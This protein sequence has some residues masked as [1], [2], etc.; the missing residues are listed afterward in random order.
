MDHRDTIIER[1]YNATVTL[2]VANRISRGIRL[3]GDSKI[4]DR[5]AILRGRLTGALKI[6]I[7]EPRMCVAFSGGVNRSIDAIR[8]LH[9][10]Q[11]I[12]LD[13]RLD[14]GD[15]Q[16]LLFEA[17]QDG[18]VEFLVATVAPKALMRVCADGV[19]PADQLWIGDHDAFEVYQRHFHEPTGMAARAHAESPEQ[20][21]FFEQVA[22][23]TPEMFSS[24][25]AR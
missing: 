18:G 9:T 10:R 14:P 7:L 25:R 20:E 23:N 22:R 17:A 13:E 12:A 6:V 8:R 2:V 21:A 11:R 19:R 3:I 5:N 24:P 16:N 15:V 1:R 4:T